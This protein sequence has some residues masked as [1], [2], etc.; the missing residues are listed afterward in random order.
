MAEKFTK[1][2][3]WQQGLTDRS[4]DASANKIFVLAVEFSPRRGRPSAIQGT[5]RKI[6]DILTSH[7]SVPQESD[8]GGSIIFPKLQVFRV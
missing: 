7:W 2:E 8:T 6:P 4:K 5:R 3:I 1:C